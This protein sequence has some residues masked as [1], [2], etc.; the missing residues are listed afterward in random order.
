[1]HLARLLRCVTLCLIA[2]GGSGFADDAQAQTGSIRGTVVATDSTTPGRRPVPG[3]Q[4]TVVGTQIGALTNDA[5]EYTIRNVPPGTVTVR[6]QRIGFT[7]SDIRVAVTAGATATADFSL[8]PVARTLSEVVVVGYGTT[9]RQNV[10]SAIAS[11]T[12]TDI[13][14][15]PTAGVDA[16]LQGKAPGVQV[17]QNAGNP[18]N[19]ISVRVRGPASINAGNQPLYVVDGVPIIQENYSQLGMGG[20]DVNAVSGINP[21][22]IETIDILKDAAAAAIYGSRGSNGVVMIT[23]KRGSAGKTHITFS[24]YN[25]W[26]NNPESIPMLDAKQYV[27]IF[28]ESAKND[29]YDPSDYDFEPGVDDAATYDWQKAVFR[30]AP[31]RNLQLGATGGSERTSYYL[32]GSYFDQQGIVIGS[33]YRRGAGRT[34]LD[35]TATN[36]LTVRTSLGLSREDNERIEGDGSLDG[37]VTNALGMQPMRPVYRDDGSYAGRAEGLRYSNPVA[38]ANLNSTELETMRA[39]GNI[40][41]NYQIASKL[42]LTGRGGF[43]VLGLDETQWESPAVDRT[44]AASAAGVGKSG[45]TG[46]SKY[47]GEGFATYEAL[48]APDNHLSIV[49][50]ASVEYNKST[51]NFIRGEG[52]TSGF[53]TYV[54]NAANVTEY[55]GAQTTNNLVGFF[56]RADW[57]LKERYL[58]SASV[59]ADGSSRFGEDNRY[60]LFPAASVG[61]VVSEEPFARGLQKVMNLK[62]RASYGATGNQGIGD[63][64]ARALASGA[65]YSGT[66]GSAVTQLANPDLRWETT[67]EF[68]T[69]ADLLFFNGRVS[70][71]ADY[72]LRKTSD[73]LVQRPIP[74]TTGF[75]TYWGNIGDVQNKGL[76][77]GLNTTNIQMGGTNGFTWH[78]ILTMTFNR[79]EVTSLFDGQPFTTGINGRETSIAQVGKPL[80]SFFMYKFDGVDPQTGDAI[81]RDVDG[82]GE[83]TAAD[84][85]IVGNPH[86]N[87]FG[88]FTN[89]FTLKNFELN[90]FLQFSQGNDVFNMMRIFADDGACTYDNKFADV[91]RRWQKPGDITD[92]PRMS[93]DCA[94]GADAISSRFI[95]D[96]SYLRLGEVT[97]GWRVPAK[98]AS[99]ARLDNAR[100][101]VSGR[102]LATWT[103]YSGYNPDVNSAGS[104]ENVIIGTDY[105]AY[106]LPRT[107]T[108]GISAGW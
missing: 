53:K 78:S 31:V 43:D 4:V 100:L 63:F 55:D 66:P 48:S 56:S 62:L 104:D 87:Y 17:M 51:L 70:L 103:K 61:W 26:Q 34:N 45:H 71:T 40:E 25:G 32:S 27:E 101:Y 106:P 22:E 84:R 54:R 8:V 39:F 69:G 15:N 28:N 42:R 75:T 107:F 60:G 88:G 49:G 83:I 67:R 41:A 98:I 85:M 24:G 74:S 47:L 73:L 96:G 97:L 99:K 93:Y 12:A 44:Y 80:G 10:S 82:D 35:F 92:V 81:L 6:A 13:A 108:L 5:G 50:G 91:M 9:N 105:Y 21:D 2:V 3:A 72:Y 1:M 57:S 37:V 33:R 19:G 29:G 102:N 16:A 94:S 18:G 58:V 59:R 14:N 95:E 68:D 86:P 76:D 20:Q 38:L 90:T 36:K 52:F 7:P 11:V 79:N 23:T 64:A 77:L 89:T 46:A 65:P 30:S